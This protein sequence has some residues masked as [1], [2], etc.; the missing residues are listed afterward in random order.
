MA[1][2]LDPGL[3]VLFGGDT[4]A[5]ILAVLAGA[6]APFSGYRVAKVARVQPIKAYAELRRLRDAGFV[7]ETASERG[8]SAW[9]LS[10]SNLR[11]FL[12]RRVRVAWWNDW[13]PGMEQRAS[14]AEEVLAKVGR[15][16]LSKF[17]PN[18]SAVSNP[19]EYV[20]PTEK[21]RVLARMGLRTSARKRR[22]R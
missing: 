19:E 17:K 11:S 21:D 14:R 15:F 1:L 5:S 7:S 3:S 4:R 12:E 18:P 13:E 10:D 22:N 6:S 2:E 8:K 20:R 16:D 9:Q